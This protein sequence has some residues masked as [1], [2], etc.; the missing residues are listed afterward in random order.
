[1]ETNRRQTMAQYVENEYQGKARDNQFELQMQLAI[2]ADARIRMFD[3]LYDDT[4]SSFDRLNEDQTS[5]FNRRTLVRTLF[6]HIEAQLSIMRQT[7][8]TWHRLGAIKLPNDDLR[9]LADEIRVT[10]DA[11]QIPGIPIRLKLID[12]IKFTYQ[13]F[14]SSLD[15]SRVDVDFSS[16]GWQSFLIAVTIRDKLMHPKIEQDLLISDSDLMHVL[17]AWNWYQEISARVFLN[18]S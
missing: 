14:I 18:R 15:R 13:I 9:K 4:R 12:S 5:Q 8:L 10:W 6:S 1:M 11:S 16:Q 17:V 3:V 7:V 2:E